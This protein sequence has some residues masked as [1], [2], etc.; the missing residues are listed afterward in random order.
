MKNCPVENIRNFV[1]TGHAGAGKTSLADQMLFKAKVVSRLGSVDQKTSVSDFRPEEQERKCSLYTAAL[2]LPWK[3]GHFFFVDTPGGAD[4]CGE[5]IAAQQIADT[6]I[7]VVD[8]AAGIGPGTLRSWKQA[9]ARNQPRLIFI[10]GLDREQADYERV[11]GALQ[12]SYGATTCIPFVVPVGA[13]A[14]LTG[15]AAV[16][17]GETPEAAQYKEKLVDAVVEADEALMARYLDGQEV[18]EAEITKG[19]TTA[20]LDGRIV[21]VFCG[22]GIKDIGVMELLD[23]I[24]SLLPNPLQGAKI[25][26]IEGELE[27]KAD[28]D[29]GIAL[30]FKSV[31]DPFIGQLSFF[32]IYS[33]KFRANT[34]LFNVTQSTKER[35]GDLLHVN[36]KEQ[37]TVDEAGPGEIVT[38][39][40]LKSTHINHTLATKHTSLQVKRVDFPKPVLSYAVFAVNKGEEEKI[41]NGVHRM[42]EEDPSIKLERSMETH[43]TLLSGMGDQHVHNVVHRLLHTFKVQVELKTPKVP[44]R[45]TITGSGSAMHRHKKQTGGHGQFAEVHLRLDPLTTA[46]YEFDSEV[47]G[48]NVPKNFIPAIEKGVVE[49]K[50]NGPLAG[51]V[52]INFKAVVFDGK[53]HP[54]DSS[55]MAFKIAARGAFRGAMANARPILLEPIMK[56][57][58]FFPEEYMGDI[59]GDLNSRRGRILGM[60]HV[61]GMQEVFAEVPMSESFT[62]SSTLR[63]ITQGRGSFEMA[64]DRY[65][66]V[67][68]MLSKQIQEAA[69]K[70]RTEETEE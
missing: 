28:A 9:K 70:G 66:P 6:A 32:R 13:N 16:L 8:A 58:V 18:T 38:V 25:P 51:C 49:A 7:I 41:A 10:N 57:Q 37:V 23:G 55:E 60:G 52:V 54:V 21:P 46:E 12:E 56:L 5:T 33:G 2:H 68:A 27:R 17:K 1:L 4:F 48:G 47:V 59:T 45:E 24:M 31:A 43:E 20:I 22:S 63:S 62:Y 44:Y 61:E 40:K 11:L 65:E 64:F 69:A 50:V 42:M 14:G 35:V 30:V 67:P 3:D 39:A 36:G 29:P 19:L 15:V 26:L 34:D 53:Y